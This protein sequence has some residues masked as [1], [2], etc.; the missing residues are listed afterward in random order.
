[1]TARD[2]RSSQKP[3]PP[4]GEDRLIARY[5]KPLATAPGAFALDDDAA[6]LRPPAGH[7]LVFTTDALVEG[8]H[9]LA[10]DAPGN[11]ARKAMRVNLSDLAAKGAHA[12]GFLLSLALPAKTDDA[13]LEA[14][15]AGLKRDIDQFGCALLGGD[16]VRSPGPLMINVAMFGTVPEGHM[17]RRA[18]ARPGD[19]VMVSGS[20][21]DAALGLKVRQGGL[22]QLPAAVRDHL[23]SRYELPLPRTE[24]ADAVREHASAAMDV[25]DGLVGDL[26]KLC[27][28]SGVSAEIEAAKV[29]LSD[30]A[31]SAL[32]ADPALR[33]AIL[34]GGDDYEIL[35]AVPAADAARLA[36]AV[37]P[38]GISFTEIGTFGAGEGVRV[39]DG[40]G[41]DLI[42]ARGSFSHF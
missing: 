12:S 41:K 24:L 31:R 25:S 39:L 4:S 11:L 28:A 40:A 26:A 23:S 10:D 32:G 36:A 1:M 13:W 30:A 33:D 19:K 16:T 38:F 20:I 42:F 37:H 29:P 15:A 22:A 34:T 35:C 17:V 7:D 6:C 18:G 9:F 27:R 21:G 5:F 14:F 2:D 3:S 8:V